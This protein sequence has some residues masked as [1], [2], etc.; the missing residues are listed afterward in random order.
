MGIKGADL[1]DESLLQI[2]AAVCGTLML[3]KAANRHVFFR[4]VR[5]IKMPRDWFWMRLCHLSQRRVGVLGIG[6]LIVFLFRLCIA[7]CIMCRLCNR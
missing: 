6:R 1:K 5:E 7:F 3:G 2:F 4:M